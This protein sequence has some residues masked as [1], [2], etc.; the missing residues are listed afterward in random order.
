MKR[1]KPNTQVR[2][3]LRNAVDTEGP[4]VCTNKQPTNIVIQNEL[5]Q[6]TVAATSVPELPKCKEHPYTAHSL[7]YVSSQIC[8]ARNRKLI[9]HDK[10]QTA[11]GN[12]RKGKGKSLIVSKRRYAMCCMTTK[13]VA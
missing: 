4:N 10:K 1:E 6:H 3:H 11:I 12:R 5:K 7:F 13:K 8:S 9:A 2:G